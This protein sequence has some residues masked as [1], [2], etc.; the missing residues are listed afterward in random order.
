M[1]A[2]EEFAERLGR[3]PWAMRAKWAKVEIHEQSPAPG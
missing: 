1:A 2:D 3:T